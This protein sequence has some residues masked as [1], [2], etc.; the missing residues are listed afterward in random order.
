VAQSEFIEE[1][2][3][4]L[5]E[6]MAGSLNDIN[7]IL[8]NVVQSP[9]DPENDGSVMRTY[10][11]ALAHHIG[12]LTVLFNEYYVLKTGVL[13]KEKSQVGFGRLLAD[14]KDD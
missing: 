8:G 1:N 6:E 7:D 11:I 3:N 12:S 5:L 9:I 4:A 2:K 14:K 13:S 10:M